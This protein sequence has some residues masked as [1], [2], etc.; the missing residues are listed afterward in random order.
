MLS[1]LDD[2]RGATNSLRDD[3]TDY[4]YFLNGR[5][6]ESW[7]PLFAICATL[8]PHRVQDLSKIAADLAAYRTRAPRLAKDLNDENKRAK[9]FQYGRDL[10]R[11]MLIV[12]GDD[13]KIFTSDVIESLRKLPTGPWRGFRSAEGI[14]ND[15]SGCML[16]ADLLEPFDVRP[17]TIWIGKE[18]GKG[19]ERKQLEK[20][21]EKFN[22]KIVSSQKQSQKTTAA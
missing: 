3:E 11:D 12:M 17:K 18:A 6:Q 20:A 13:Q 15:R 21:V 4:L 7:R 1:R 22:I 10:I 16:L 2:I 19:Y 8:C 5:D 9:D 14:Q